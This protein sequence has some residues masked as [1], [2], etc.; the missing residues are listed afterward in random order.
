MCIL[1]AVSERVVITQQRNYQNTKKGEMQFSA[2]VVG[3]KI[4][5]KC[6]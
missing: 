1:M 4:F 3:E 2:E 5:F 6:P